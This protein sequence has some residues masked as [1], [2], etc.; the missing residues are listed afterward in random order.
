LIFH[1]TSILVFVSPMGFIMIVFVPL[2]GPS[3]IFI[4]T[5]FLSSRITVS[6][7]VEF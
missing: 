3:V 7:H 4:L 5:D 1:I 2:I 6:L